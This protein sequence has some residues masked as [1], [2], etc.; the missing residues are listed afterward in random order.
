MYVLTLLMCLLACLMLAF[1][2]IPIS[3]FIFV[4]VPLVPSV[5]IYTNTYAYRAVHTY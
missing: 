2:L 4:Q 5:Y 1:L 3:A